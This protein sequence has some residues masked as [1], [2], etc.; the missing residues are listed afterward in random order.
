MTSETRSSAEA[1]GGTTAPEGLSVAHELD[2]RGLLC[3]MPVYLT[4]KEMSKLDEGD[5]LRVVCTD[6]GAL[7]DFPAFA[8]QHGHKLIAADE[9][10]DEQHILL[11]KGGG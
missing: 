9:Q 2:C 7:Q 10:G 6:R 8:N 3:P 4:S 11:R 1:T 5:V